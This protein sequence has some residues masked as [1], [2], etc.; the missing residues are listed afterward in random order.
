MA[1]RRS[2]LEQKFKAGSITFQEVMELVN[3]QYNM[4]Q[5]RNAEALIR[6]LLNSNK[7]PPEGLMSVAQFM[8]QKRKLDIVELALKKYTAAKP[9]DTQGWINL[10]GLQLALNKRGRNVELPTKI[11]R[12]RRRTG[13]QPSA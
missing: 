11:R 2:E 8:A 5:S 10:A 6:N 7:V 12:N 13:A 1:A 3:I 9:K 4:G